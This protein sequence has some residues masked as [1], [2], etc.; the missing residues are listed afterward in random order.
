MKWIYVLIVF[1]SFSSCGVGRKVKEG[2]RRKDVKNIAELYK[3]FDAQKIHYETLEAKVK[4][5]YKDKRSSIP[6]R[7]TVRIDKGK[8][9]WISGGMF[10]YEAVRALITPDSVQVIN[11][12]KK[13]YYKA[14]ISEIQTL[15]G[16]PADFKML[17]NLITGNVII[18]SNKGATYKKDS[19][20]IE[21]LSSLNYMELIASFRKE[22][23]QLISQS[24]SDT[25]HNQSM[26]V[27]YA[28]YKMVDDQFYF[29]F[30]NKVNVL[31]ESI[32]MEFDFLSIKINQNPS[33]EFKINKRYE[34]KKF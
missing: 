23:G 34:E 33:F 22:N 11:R 14:P 24:L 18:R 1:V 2:E 13:Q 16:F 32:L 12:L 29:P 26:N 20:A 10:G 28:N 15:L 6:F 7:A 5:K 9:I 8:K 30:E 19:D 17:E 4:I 31:S 25:L 3:R 21:I 27:S